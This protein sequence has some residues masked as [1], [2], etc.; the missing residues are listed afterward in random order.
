MG[1]PLEHD[2]FYPGPVCWRYL[3]LNLQRKSWAVHRAALDKFAGGAGRGA[4]GMPATCRRKVATSTVFEV[5]LRLCTRLPCTRSSLLEHHGHAPGAHV[6]PPY[7]PC[8]GQARRLAAKFRALGAKPAAEASLTGAG[9]GAGAG[10]GAGGAIQEAVADE[11]Q[12]A[13]GGGGGGPGGKAASRW[14]AGTSK[15]T[16]LRT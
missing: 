9:P 1:L 5:G 12:A 15:G 11:H 10:T 8:P 6:M 3:T 13:G 2:S 4:A 7:R 14:V 16:G